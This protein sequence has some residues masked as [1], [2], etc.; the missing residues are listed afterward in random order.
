MKKIFYIVLI[1]SMLTACETKYD[2][3]GDFGGFWQQT[4][5]HVITPQNDTTEVNVKGHIYWSV[6]NEYLVLNGYD[7]QYACETE[8]TSKILKIKKIYWENPYGTIPYDTILQPKDIKAEFYFPDNGEFTIEKL[9]AKEM[10][11]TAE[12]GG[13][14]VVSEYRK[15]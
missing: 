7:Q 12:R 11:L 3:A 2:E 4:K 6:R 13:N 9:T 14:K 1:F 10:K 5:L 8:R 15:Y